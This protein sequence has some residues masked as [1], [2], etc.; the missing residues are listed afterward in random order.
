MID[1]DLPMLAADIAGLFSRY[2]CPIGAD[3]ADILPALPAFIA[4]ITANAEAADRWMAG[5]DAAH[6]HPGLDTPEPPRL[7]PG[8]CGEQDFRVWA[9]ELSDAAA[10]D[11][12]AEMLRD[13]DWGA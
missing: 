2:G 7:V 4:Q 13:P 8:S 9:R 10:L 1:T 5:A 11:D 6:W 12:I 3:G